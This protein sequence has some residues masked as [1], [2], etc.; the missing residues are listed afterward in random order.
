M[1][2][3]DLLTYLRA[4]TIEEGE[5][6]LWQRATTGEGHPVASIGG[7]RSIP[8]RRWAWGVWHGAEPGDR[9][10]VCRCAEPRCV[11]P[12]HLEAVTPSGMNR[13][14]VK[15]GRMSTPAVAAARREIARRASPLTQADVI[16][17]R[18]RRAAGE[19]L[20]EIAPDFPVGYNQISKIC[21]YEAWA[22]VGNLWHG[23][24]PR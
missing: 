22:E 16:E 10:I 14:L 24:V 23:L 15:H 19:K 13:W 2:P 21:R 11:W 12:G 7:R 17:I 5:C 9:R 1:T 8:V 20:R 6:W 4:R 18:R 3:D